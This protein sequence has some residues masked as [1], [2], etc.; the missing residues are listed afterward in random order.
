MV[1]GAFRVCAFF[2]EI[3]SIVSLAFPE[4]SVILERLNTPDFKEPILKGKANGY[5]K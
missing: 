2:L 3:R 4:E 5:H 1:C